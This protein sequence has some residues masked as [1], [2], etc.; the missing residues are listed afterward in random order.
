MRQRRTGVAPAEVAAAAEAS[1]AAELDAIAARPD[2]ERLDAFLRYALER[3]QVVD[4]AYSEARIASMLAALDVDDTTRDVVRRAVLW[5]QRDEALHA[6]YLRGRLLR[7][8]RV[9]SWASIFAIQ[10]VGAVGGWCSSVSPKHGDDAFR[11]RRVVARSILTAGSVTGQLPTALA[12]ALKQPGFEAFCRVNAVLEVSAIRAYEQLM[13]LLAGDDRPLFERILADEI[14]HAQ[15][16]ETFVDC[17]DGETLRLGMTGA[18]LATRLCAISPY[19][20]GA[21][22]RT[23]R[24]AVGPTDVFVEQH[25]RRRNAVLGAMDAVDLASMVDG[26]TVAIRTNFMLAY[27]RADATTYVA[28]E[29][30]SA[31]VD[32]LHA[33]GAAEVAVIDAPNIYD[34]YFDGRS[35]PEVADY[36]GLD[37]AD[38]RFRLVD[39]TED[40]VRI[41]ADRGLVTTSACRTWVEADVRIVVAKLA[42]DPSEVVHGALATIPGLA[43]RIEDEQFYTHRLVDHRTSAMM[44]LEI[45][46]L[47]LAV[48]DAWG[49]LGDGPLGVMGCDRPSEQSR[50]YVG[51]DAAAVDATVISD[52]GVDPS[53]SEILRR[54]DQWFGTTHADRSRPSRLGVMPGFRAPQGSA[55][56]RLVSATAVPVYANLSGSGRLFVPRVDEAAFPPADR[57]G[58]F[59]R[60]VRRA[61]Q[62]VFGLHPGKARR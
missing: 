39:A 9:R 20:V 26:R 38:P 59:V 33:A 62:R 27:D 6:Q 17:F 29:T 3:E 36:L 47:D 34:R 13:P 1:V 32:A 49:P 18:A 12:L 16:F 58:A 61:A 48:V 56:Y 19:L 54:A 7:T 57:P 60:I 41:D 51:T 28:P 44:L 52:M 14:R 35:V 30:I 22:G 23:Q 21:D 45:A 2:D 4:V 37:P 53:A 5:L 15:V 50:I 43:G 8:R 10:L 24:D 55:W 46:P 25:D 11:L 40:M 31:T 42:G